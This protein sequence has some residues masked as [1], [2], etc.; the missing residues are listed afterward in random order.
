MMTTCRHPASTKACTFGTTSSTVPMKWSAATASPAS[1][2]APNASPQDR[3]ERLGEGAHPS[4]GLRELVAE[5]VELALIPAA[6][7]TEDQPAAGEDVDV[8]GLL[9]E[10]RRVPV[11]G[12]RHEL[13]EP[14]P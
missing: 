4:G 7:E 5:R 12:A 3:L 1:A 10:Q 6:A 2:A 9:G 11:G 13:A 8:G 14:G